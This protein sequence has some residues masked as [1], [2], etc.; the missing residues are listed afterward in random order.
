MSVYLLFQQVQTVAS[1]RHT[2]ACGTHGP[3]P[4]PPPRTAKQTLVSLIAA[5]GFA[6]QR[7]KF[8]ERGNLHSI[9]CPMSRETTSRGLLGWEKKMK[10][11]RLVLM[12]EPVFRIEPVCRC[13]DHC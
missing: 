2:G 4:L 9:S 3:I 10:S 12:I 7:S 1:I 13:C 11:R 5:I 8:F 6:G